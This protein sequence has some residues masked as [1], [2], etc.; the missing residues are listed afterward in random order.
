MFCV[1]KTLSILEIVV[2]NIY[3]FAPQLHGDHYDV[4]FRLLVLVNTNSKKKKNDI[5]QYL[6]ISTSIIIYNSRYGL[7][8]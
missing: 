2:N 8:A 1:L 3:T 7:R 6:H 5:I 4:R